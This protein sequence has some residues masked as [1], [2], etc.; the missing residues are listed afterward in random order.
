MAADDIQI[1]T[2]LLLP[3]L[4]D[5]SVYDGY[6]DQV[7]DRSSR[8]ISLSQLLRGEVATL[9]REDFVHIYCAGTLLLEQVLMEKR[10][11]SSDRGKSIELFINFV[12]AAKTLDEACTRSCQFNAILEERGYEHRLEKNAQRARFVIGLPLLMSKALPSLVTSTVAYFINL[13]SWLIGRP[14]R[15]VATGLSSPSEDE[16]LQFMDIYQ[17]PVNFGSETNYFEFDVKDLDAK[18]IQG[19]DDLPGL[20]DYISHDPTFFS[21]SSAPTSNRV[22]S[23]LFEHARTGARLPDGLRTAEQLGISLS[24]LTRRL[25]RENSS[26]L[27]LKAECQ[28]ETALTL[29][30]NSSLTLP[31][32]AVRLGFFDV[33]SFR[34]AFLSW[35]GILPSVFRAQRENDPGS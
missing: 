4:R 31:E 33:R 5:L 15:L 22:R 19:P 16:I 34:R 1:P 27:K 21:R 10:A 14:I 13:F 12:T 8:R 20:V 32:I 28:Q 9:D 3:L 26:F 30:K 2:K 24:T 7:L 17:V 35:T 18:T 25:A 29:L 6:V 23:L 11:R